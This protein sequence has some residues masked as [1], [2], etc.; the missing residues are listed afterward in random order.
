[1]FKCLN[2]DLFCAA[3]SY[4]KS[5]RRHELIINV[6]RQN[7][8]FLPS[9]TVEGRLGVQAWY[10]YW[11]SLPGSNPQGNLFFWCLWM[12]FGRFMVFVKVLKVL[13]TH[14]PGHVDK[15]ALGQRRVLGCSTTDM[16]LSQFEATFCHPISVAQT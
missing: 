10:S 12:T 8:S 13:I 16:N 1:M 3:A 7:I 14:R 11:L 9:R 4:Y 5:N 2:S 6:F 15:S